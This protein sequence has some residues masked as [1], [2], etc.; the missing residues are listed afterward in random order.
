MKNI[1][2]EFNKFL[3]YSEFSRCLRPATVRGHKSV[4]EAFFNIMPEIR[5]VEDV[6]PEV[7]NLFFKRLQTR[8]RI[9]GKGI[10]KTGVRDST[11]R[12]YWSKMNSFFVWLCSQDVVKS[13]PFEKVLCPYPEYTDK[14]TLN[15]EEIQRII[16]AITLNS[17]NHLLM[18]RDL[19]IIDLL[20]FCGL[21]KSELLGL[22]VTDVDLQRRILSVRGETSKSKET[23]KIPMNSS[24]LMHMSDYLEERKLRVTEYLLVS[25]DEDRGLSHSGLVHW[26]RRM[27]KKTQVKFHLHQFR[28]TFAHNLGCNNVNSVKI[29]KL[30]GHRDLRMTERYLR[31]MVPDDMRTDIEQLSIDTLM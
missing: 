21:R 7:I 15:K 28:H 20:L 29:Q 17:K 16:T 10:K 25:C 23:R 2:E 6:T 5:S 22:K 4:M 24:L 8:T 19:L 30:M 13:N 27:N 18:K 14:K 9:V 31:S 3:E 11:I 26:V 1:R 12:T